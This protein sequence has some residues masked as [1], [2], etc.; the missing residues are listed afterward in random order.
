MGKT[1]EKN[2][3][4]MTTP[5]KTILFLCTGNYY[6]SRFAEELFNSLATER[7]PAWKAVSRALAIDRGFQNHGPISIHALNELARRNLF[8]THPIREPLQCMEVDLADADHIIALK[9][10]EHRPQL[11]K[12][13]PIWTDRVEY[14]HI[15][16]VDQ[17]SPEES[18]GAIFSQVD[19]LILEL[20]SDSQA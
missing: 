13:F 18:L 7:L 2:F 14:W 20:A 4:S 8:L 19:R 5:Q 1:N 9:E 11:E 6:R 10:E 17:A 12:S 15:H 16:D 3:P